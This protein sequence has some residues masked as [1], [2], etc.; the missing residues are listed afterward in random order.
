MMGCSAIFVLCSSY[1]YANKGAK[2]LLRLVSVSLCIVYSHA[3]QQW[4]IEAEM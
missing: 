3:M 4:M 1:R 2:K